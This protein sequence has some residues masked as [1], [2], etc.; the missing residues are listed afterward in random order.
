MVLCDI[1]TYER[2]WVSNPP[3]L[4]HSAPVLQ[5]SSLYVRTGL[6]VSMRL[7]V[8]L[9]VCLS[10]VCR[11]YTGLSARVMLH[12]VIFVVEKNTNH[13]VGL[14][15]I[16]SFCKINEIEVFVLYVSLISSHLIIV[17]I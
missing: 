4:L 12:A 5:T 16:M 1:R 15:N 13:D 8:C 3:T 10:K 6:Y 14:C 11:P 2:Q 9:Y 17:S 7:F